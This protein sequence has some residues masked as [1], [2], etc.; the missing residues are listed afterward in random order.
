MTEAG[1]LKE[2]QQLAD[3]ARVLVPRTSDGIAHE[4][5]ARGHTASDEF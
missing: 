3:P 2:G 5:N 4:D 1:L